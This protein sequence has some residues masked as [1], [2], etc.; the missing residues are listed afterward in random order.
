MY[1]SVISGLIFDYKDGNTDPV[2]QSVDTFIHFHMANIIVGTFDIMC[3]PY[4]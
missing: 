4:A 2:S 3:T 1:I